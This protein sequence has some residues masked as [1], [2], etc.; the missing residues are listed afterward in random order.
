ML[1]VRKVLLLNACCFFAAFVFNYFTHSPSGFV[2][3]TAG[4]FVQQIMLG[5]LYGIILSPGFVVVILYYAETRRLRLMLKDILVI[6]H[7][8]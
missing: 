8:R 7:R 6:W 5:V 1:I 3:L 2:S 4:D